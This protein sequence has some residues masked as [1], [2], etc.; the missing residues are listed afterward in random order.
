MHK[1]VILFEPVEDWQVFEKAWPQF[2]HLVEAMPGLRSEASS[3]VEAFLFGS[4][5]YV[6]MHELFFDSLDQA[7]TA[8]ASPQGQVAGRVLQ[9]MTGGKV[10]LFIAEHK[11][12]DLS[13]IQ[14]YT[15]AG[16]AWN[17]VE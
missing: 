13:H 11:Q 3:Q 5:Q 4:C 16:S 12:D 8:M 2:L 6:Q 1:L 7:R 14:Q 17:T 9:T 15:G 10:N